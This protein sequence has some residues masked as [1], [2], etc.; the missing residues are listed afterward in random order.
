MDRNN[1]PHKEND[2]KCGSLLIATL[3]IS[4]LREVGKHTIVCAALSLGVVYL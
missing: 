1:K 2:S 4:L 3:G